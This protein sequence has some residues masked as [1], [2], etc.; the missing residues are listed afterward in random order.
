[1]KRGNRYKD[2]INSYCQDCG[3]VTYHNI[4]FHT[5]EHSAE[6]DFWWVEDYYVVECCGCGK[7]S[8]LLETVDESDERY[9][10]EDGTTVY[11]SH[12]R[13]FPYN[14]G[15]VD[16]LEYSFEI[17]TK[18]NA[19]YRETVSSLNNGNN[20]LAAAGFRA[21]IEAICLELSI[22]GANL[23]KKINGL[24]K[25]GHITKNDR[26]RLHSVRFIGNDSIHE[27]KGPD[28]SSLKLV[29]KIIN[30]LLYNLYIL[31]KDCKVLE[32]PVKTF[33]D[34]QLIID[35]TIAKHTS[36]Q[37]LSFK[38]LTDGARRIISEDKRELENLLQAKINDGTYT[39][40]IMC[41]APQSGSAPQQYKIV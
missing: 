41:A 18:V 31:E 4:L 23:E 16:A 11:E 8:F 2:R 3:K 6:D 1:M 30:N 14:G 37:V 32:S 29:L 15:N 25:A 35:Q 39:K 40:L 22:Q 26:D 13:T 10:T 24:Y 34:L 9:D 27:I 17:P 36:G 20:R 19:I 28:E 7:K 5:S 38:N 33:E 12:F 21:T